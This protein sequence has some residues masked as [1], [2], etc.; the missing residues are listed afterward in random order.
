MRGYYKK[1]ILIFAGLLAIT[2]ILALACWNMVFVRDVLLPERDNVVRW[3][4]ETLTDAYR[5]GTSS[6]SINDSAA[7]LDY[8]YV[9]TGAVK[10]PHVTAIISFTGGQS[11]E[12]FAD[13]SGY[14]TAALRVKCEPRNVLTFHLHGFDPRATLPGDF[15][16][17]RIAKAFFP[18]NDEWSEVEID[19]SHLYVPEWWLNRF[20]IEISDQ[21]YSLDKVAALSIVASVEGPPVNM[22]ANV[23]IGE[24]ALLRQDW[25]YAWVFGGVSLLVWAG[26]IFWLFRQ[27]TRSLIA[28]V[29]GRLQQD[30]ALMAYRQLT[31]EPQTEPEKVMLLRFMAT[32]YA[33]PDLS[34]E[35]TIAALGINR[36]KINEILKKELGLTFTACLNKL[37]LTEA[38]RLLSEN[39]NANVA[40]IAYTVGYNNVTYFNRLFKQEYGSTPKAF[41]SVCRSDTGGDQPP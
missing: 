9:L 34:L 36:T 27:Y 21:N 20:K 39:E 29:K 28:D 6:I 32:R 1:A 7:S 38:A 31:A 37:R 17:Y 24:L 13:L 12:R 16:S 2:F 8:D 30:L 23:K 40:E 25:R 15:Y 10:Y 26:F 18:C 22:P 4:L 3:K 19:L 41:K 14:S 35:K 11:P 5:G 33:D